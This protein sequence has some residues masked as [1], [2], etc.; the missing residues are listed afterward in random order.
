MRVEVFQS[1]GIRAVLFRVVEQFYDGDIEGSAVERATTQLSD[2]EQ[3]VVEIP[4]QTFSLLESLEEPQRVIVLEIQQRTGLSVGEIIARRNDAR[5][6]LQRIHQ[7][8]S[9][10][11]LP[12]DSNMLRRIDQHMES[13]VVSTQVR[14]GKIP[15]AVG[16]DRLGLSQLRE[17]K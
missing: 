3:P 15:A 4:E 11:S 8:T 12:G 10:R 16:R 7:S 1:G 6:A 14:A 2:S 17:K 13:L 9:N 5:E